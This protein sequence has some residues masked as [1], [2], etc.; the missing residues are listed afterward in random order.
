MTNNQPAAVKPT[1]PRSPRDLPD[2]YAAL[3][4]AGPHHD[5]ARPDAIEISARAAARI[6][7][8]DATIEREEGRLHSALA[9]E[10]VAKQHLDALIPQAETATSELALAQQ[11]VDAT[12]G[13]M[14]AAQ[15][16]RVKHEARVAEAANELEQMRRELSRLE[17][18]TAEEAL[19]GD[20]TRK[21]ADALKHLDRKQLDEIRQLHK[22]PNVVRR[23][24]ALVQALP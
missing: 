12:S 9:R 3:G 21:E 8:L 23:A 17:G 15:Q 13:A 6:A 5:A 14:S 22:P 4:M 11:A 2:V 7:E 1:T 10:A 24:M 20:Q 18:G 16:D 19:S